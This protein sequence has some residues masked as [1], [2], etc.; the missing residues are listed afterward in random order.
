MRRLLAVLFL[1][2]LFFAK[3][4][5]FAQAVPESTQTATPLPSAAAPAQNTAPLFAK[6]EVIP[7]KVSPHALALRARWVTVPGWSIATFVAAHSQLNTG[8]SVGMEYLYRRSGF[9]VVLSLDYSWLEADPGNFLGK[10]NNPAT[11]THFLRFDKLSSLSFDAALIGHWNLTSWLEFRLGAGLGIG[12][13]FGNIYQITNNSGCTEANAADSTK[14]YPQKV[15]PISNMDADTLDRLNAQGCP[16]DDS[17]LDTPKNPCVR[18]TQTYPFNARVVPVLNTTFGFRFKFHDHVYWHLDAGWRLV[19][20]YVGG[21]PEF[22][23]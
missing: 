21:G 19:G 23:F 3:T 18:S 6:P 9:D 13:V 15:G 16:N 17:S 22:R 1:A 11:E 10:G 4:P 12:Y 20:F 5:A 2:S 14:C 8:W 7:S